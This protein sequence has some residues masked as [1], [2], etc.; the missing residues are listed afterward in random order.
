MRVV[1]IGLRIERRIGRDQG[2]AQLMRE[3][4]QVWLCCALNLVKPSGHFDVAAVLEYLADIVGV[5]I[6]RIRLPFGKMLRNPAF[7]ASRQA[8]EAV[9][10]FGKQ[11]KFDMGRLM[12]GPVKMGGGHQRAEI[13][14]P[15]LI[16]RIE[17]E[18]IIGGGHSVRPVGAL[19]REECAD[20]RLDTRSDTGG[21]KLHRPVKP[22]AVTDGDGGKTELA[23]VFGNRLGINRAFEHGEGGKDTQRDKGR[24]GHRGDLRQAGRGWEQGQMR[25]LGITRSFL[26]GCDLAPDVAHR[27][28]S[29]I[30]NERPEKRPDPHRDIAPGDGE[31]KIGRHKP[32]ARAQDRCDDG[33][34]RP[35]A[36]HQPS[37]RSHKEGDGPDINRAENIRINAV[38]RAQPHEPAVDR[39]NA[40]SS[41]SISDSRLAG[42]SV[43]AWRDTTLPSLSIRNLVKFHLIP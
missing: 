28:P 26:A 37:N 34:A 39:R 6:S 18:P 5:V 1:K 38:L 4:D 25:E 36:P 16:L 15:R 2:Q 23:R 35:L 12:I 27:G 42:F 43:G 14:I 13:I 20:D 24:E 40:H 9:S 10:M 41:F 3:L 33:P 32:E 30:N 7:A 19:D 17:G 21:R 8:N 29:P 31:V 22:V 11:I